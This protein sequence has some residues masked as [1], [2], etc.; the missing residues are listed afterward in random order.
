MTAPQDVREEH[1]SPEVPELLP[2]LSGD[3]DAIESSTSSDNL[4]LPAGGKPNN[5]EEEI[6]QACNSVLSVVW[7]EVNESDICIR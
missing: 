4:M 3:D 1:L 2:N 7:E 5:L 6:T